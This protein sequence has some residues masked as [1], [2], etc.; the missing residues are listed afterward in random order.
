MSTMAVELF[1]QPQALETDAIRV[2]T[3][4]DFATFERYTAPI[5]YLTHFTDG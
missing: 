4:Q 5:H 2:A 1:S 3:S